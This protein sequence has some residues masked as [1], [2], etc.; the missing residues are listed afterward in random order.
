[1]H[2]WTSHV[3]DMSPDRAPVDVY[4][5]YSNLSLLGLILKNK[6]VNAVLS[7]NHI[8]VFSVIDSLAHLLRDLDV[9]GLSGEHQGD[10][11]MSL[12]IASKSCILD[13]CQSRQL[14]ATRQERILF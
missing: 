10:R 5:L 12:T 7:A 9:Q 13:Q 1:M 14:L 3:D 2:S 11:G 8:Q 6:T 4:K